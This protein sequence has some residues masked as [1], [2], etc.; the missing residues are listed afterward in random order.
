[1]RWNR[2]I[3]EIN[4]KKDEWAGGSIKGTKRGAAK[5]RAN[6]SPFAEKYTTLGGSGSKFIMQKRRYGESIVLQGGEGKQKA[7]AGEAEIVT[8]IPRPSNEANHVFTF[9][10]KQNRE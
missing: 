6:R 2:V 9:R 5:S 1:V 8:F 7:V 10:G 3:K 4:Q